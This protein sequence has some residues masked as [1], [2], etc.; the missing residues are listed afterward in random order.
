MSILTPKPNAKVPSRTSSTVR[1]GVYCVL[2]TGSRASI[3]TTLFPR[4]TCNKFESQNMNPSKD[5]GEPG[6]LKLTTIPISFLSFPFSSTVLSTTRFINWSNP[7]SVPTTVRLALSL[8]A[9]KV[10]GPRKS[11]CFS[12]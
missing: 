11:D 3:M 5:H 2:L 6:K 9:K 1:R 4:S 10:F 8:T 7:R 12:K